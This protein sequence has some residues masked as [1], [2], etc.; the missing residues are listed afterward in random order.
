MGCPQWM[1]GAGICSADA[2][3]GT[4][5]TELLAKSPDS[6]STGS[7]ESGSGPGVSSSDTSTAV[8]KPPH[9]GADHRKLVELLD[10]QEI[11]QRTLSSLF[12][13]DFNNTEAW[14]AAWHSKATQETWAI[15]AAG[16]NV[17]VAS[18]SGHQ[19]LAKQLEVAKRDQAAVGMTTFHLFTGTV[20]YQ[21]TANFAHTVTRIPVELYGKGKPGPVLD[22]PAV[23]EDF[24]VKTASGWQLVLRQLKIQGCP[25][26]LQRFCGEGVVPPDVS[27]VP[28]PTAHDMDAWGR[29]VVAPE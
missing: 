3:F 29:E 14:L 5:P 18:Y 7:S 9:K 28:L 27:P 6:S 25:V 15:N 19:G 22:V 23:C 11:Q 12:A 20:Y 24:V 17:L 2:G 1:E 13:W 8:Q 10:K 26:Y 16:D 4:F 21:K